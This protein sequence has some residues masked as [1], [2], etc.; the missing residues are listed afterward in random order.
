MRKEMKKLR[1]LC[2]DLALAGE[3]DMADKVLCAIAAISSAENPQAHLSY[4]YV[5]RDLRKKHKD[6]V[7]Q[8]QTVF[9]NTFDKAKGK[10]MDNSEEVALLAGLKK[11]DV[12][13]E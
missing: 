1:H 7:L 5:M 9:K 11:I 2:Q 8:F 6:K 4:S 3:R 13:I 10:G 12:E